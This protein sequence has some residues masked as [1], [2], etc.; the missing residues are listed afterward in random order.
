MNSVKRARYRAGVSVK[1]AADRLGISRAA[2]YQYERGE[3]TPGA[4]IA[5][6]L[7]DLY[8]TTVDD[9]LG[10]DDRSAA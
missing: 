6:G 3:L 7:A 10:L 2:I 1:D 4:V 8:G 5:K 9:L